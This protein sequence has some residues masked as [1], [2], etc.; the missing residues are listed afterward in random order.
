VPFHLPESPASIRTA[1][2]LLGEHT[3][4]VLD[5]LGYAEEEV[6]QLR[7]AGVV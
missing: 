7:A 2:P 1:P 4:E 3:D 6:A 5:E